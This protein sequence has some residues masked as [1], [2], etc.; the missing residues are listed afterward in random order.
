[1]SDILILLIALALPAPV[2]APQSLAPI[3]LAVAAGGRL[4]VL[5]RSGDILAL[6]TGHDGS[7][8]RL[9]TS[10]PRGAVPVALDANPRQD[11]FYVL[12]RSG[13]S[14][15]AVCTLLQYNLSGYASTK[16]DLDCFCEGIALDLRELRAYISDSA[17][18][19]LLS[20]NLSNPAGPAPETWP[21]PQ[22]KRLGGIVF[23]DK[24]LYVTDTLEGAVYSFDL[25]TRAATAL[26]PAKP[27]RP[28]ADD[29]RAS[30]SS[31]S[32]PLDLAFDPSSGRLYVADEQRDCVWMIDTRSP[33]PSW[34]RFLDLKSFR[35]YKP[36]AGDP[37]SLALDP[38]GRLWIG[39]TGA[40]A[41]FAV[42]VRTRRLLRIIP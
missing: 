7:G 5:D 24:S 22:A 36:G 11:F 14:K 20:V 19:V 29:P 25:A 27:I 10:F 41:L 3:S 21:L 37:V 12:T 16:Q 28:G 8:L 23:G 6:D 9:I 42:D 40:Q 30:P 17:R 31:I 38:A 18:N 4:L 15:G 32:D 2:R 39:D 34:T 13:S 1:M 35:K 26:P 33:N